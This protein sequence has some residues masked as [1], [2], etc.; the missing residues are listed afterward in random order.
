MQVSSSRQHIR[1][2]CLHWMVNGPWHVRGRIL[3]TANAT[4]AAA[5]D[6]HDH[7]QDAVLHAC[8]HIS[9]TSSTAPKEHSNEQFL[10]KVQ[11][12]TE[13]TWQHMPPAREMEEAIQLADINQ[14]PSL[15]T[16][17]T[18]YH[19]GCDVDRWLTYVCPQNALHP[20][21]VSVWQPH[22]GTRS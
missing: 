5:R 10:G 12:T 19:A 14:M 16:L 18:S 1:S 3:L 9:H 13:L 21:C 17:K 2:K 4:L 6:S 7:F 20:V 11:C 15:A 8:I 22:L